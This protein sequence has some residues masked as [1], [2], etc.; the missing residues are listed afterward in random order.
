MEFLRKFANIFKCKGSSQ[1]AMTS[2]INE[3]FLRQKVFPYFVQKL[4]YWVAVYTY[5]II[6]SKTFVSRCRQTDI[7]PTIYRLVS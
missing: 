5:R 2:A 3:K 7:S 6:F 1:V 4:L